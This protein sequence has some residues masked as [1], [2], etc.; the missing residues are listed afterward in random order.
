MA[1]PSRSALWISFV[2]SLARSR[3]STFVS[4]AATSQRLPAKPAAAR[5]KGSSFEISRPARRSAPAWWA[6]P[7]PPG[8]HSRPGC[9][10]PAAATAL[11]LGPPRP[12]LR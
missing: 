12:G 11:T 1:F 3:K 8:V 4:H 9:A 10:P 7:G 6:R 2:R 5:G